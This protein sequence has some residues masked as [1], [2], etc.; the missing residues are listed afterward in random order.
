MEKIKTT[1]S[2]YMAASGLTE[3]TT[4]TDNRHICAVADFA[5][6]ARDQLQYVNEHSWNNFKLRIGWEKMSLSHF[7]TIFS[8]ENFKSITI[9]FY[10]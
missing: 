6:A 4:F 5:F 2:T 1:G 10:G 8:L 9:R 3:E 7:Q